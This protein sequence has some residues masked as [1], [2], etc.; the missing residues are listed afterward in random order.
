MP[1]LPELKKIKEKEREISKK[2]KIKERESND[3][4]RK[5]TKLKKREKKLKM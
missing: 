2:I 4:E 5:L 1:V 3:L